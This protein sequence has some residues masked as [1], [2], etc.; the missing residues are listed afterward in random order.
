MEAQ[1]GEETADMAKHERSHILPQFKDMGYERTGY[2]M[3]E[4]DNEVLGGIEYTKINP[5]FEPR[6]VL[7][8]VEFNILDNVMGDLA[9]SFTEQ[10]N[11]NR[12][13]LGVYHELH[14]D[15]HRDTCDNFS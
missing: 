11:K 15:L 1:Y 10:R 9:L 2:S 12:T 8:K 14:N 6:N 7:S 13:E 5:A 4:V 3:Y